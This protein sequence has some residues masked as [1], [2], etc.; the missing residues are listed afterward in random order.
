MGIYK[1]LGLSKTEKMRHLGQMNKILKTVSLLPIYL[2]AATAFGAHTQ[3]RL[4]LDSETARA[5]D[6][7]MAGVQLRMDARWH[8]YWR[9][10]GDSGTPTEIDWDLPAGITA[11]EIRWPIPRKLDD[12][13][14][15]TYVYDDEVMLI[16]P[17][18]LSADLKPGH[19]EIKAK[20]SCRQCDVL[21]VPGDS[22]VRATLKIGE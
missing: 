12:E 1:H 20:V 3:V 10:S 16:V 13:D 8:T 19:S 14:L 18:K 5:G 21:C 2:W 7:V 17:L 11:G 6:N 4:L 22:K 9:N 15:T